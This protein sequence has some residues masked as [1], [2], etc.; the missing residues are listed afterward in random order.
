[1]SRLTTP[2]PRPPRPLAWALA[3]IA[4]VLG[5]D[6]EPPRPAD[7]RP[8]PAPLAI[9][10]PST[11]APPPTPRA[12]YLAS[13][14]G[15]AL[16]LPE[17]AES[18]LAAGERALETSLRSP[19]PLQETVAITPGGEGGLAI[20]LDARR[21]Q[22]LVI[23]VRPADGAEG[24][25]FVDLVAIDEARHGDRR[26]LASGDAEGMITHDVGGGELVLRVQPGLTTAGRFEVTVDVDPS[27]DFPVLGKDRRAMHSPFGAPRSG[28]RRRHHGVDIFAPMGTSTVAVIDGVV[29]RGRGHRGGNYVWIRDEE[30]G[31]SLYYA[32]LSQVFVNTGQRVRVGEVIGRVGKTGNAETT[33]P[34]LHFGVYQ[35][36]AV[37]PA[38][39]LRDEPTARAA[40]RLGDL[41]AWMR[42]GRGG[43]TLRPAPTR[44]APP[45]AKIEHGIA[46][47]VLGVRR[48]FYRVALDD[49]TEGYVQAAALTSTRQRLS[50][51]RLREATALHPTPGLAGAPVATIAAGDRVELLARADR[52]L[53]VRGASGEAGWIEAE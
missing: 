41:G 11:P 46:A 28:G 1:M 38:P 12:A 2:P 36:S 14:R 50:R 31:I 6:P 27:L 10:A 42:A 49:G 19:V 34:H 39:F 32:H 45:V 16:Y 22:R 53:L 7:P 30:R 52:A 35:R 25:I 18:W 44:D 33:A 4:L 13:L 24:P 48:G 26:L 43:A 9:A 47:R 21:G 17:H 37:D 3:T 29:Q 40:E 23:A 8:E 5:C 20:R 51:L 15:E